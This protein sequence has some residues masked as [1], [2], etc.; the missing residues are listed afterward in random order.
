MNLV[1]NRIDISN[2]LF[3]TRT[4]LKKSGLKTPRVELEEI[5]PSLDLVVRRTRLASEELYKQALKRPKFVKVSLYWSL[6]M[7]V[8]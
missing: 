5:G 8:I 7:L 2:I 4:K 3:F 1:F 6:N